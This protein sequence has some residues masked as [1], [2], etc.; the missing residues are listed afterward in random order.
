MSKDDIT[1]VDECLK[2]SQSKIYDNSDLDSVLDTILYLARKYTHSDAGSIYLAESDHLRFSYVQNDTLFPDLAYGNR[3]VYTNFN[4]PI[5]ESSIAGYAASKLETLIID[6]AYALNSSLPYSF[7]TQFDTSSGYKTV[8]MLTLPM[9]LGSS[10]LVGV[11]QL[12]NAT[13][14]NGKRR[15]YAL[16]EVWLAEKL[17]NEAAIAIEKAK[18]TRSI[19]L[20]MI[21]MA[22]LRDPKETG[23]HVN[24]VGAYSIE[25]YKRW[26]K[27]VNLSHSEVKSY[28]DALRISAMLH[29]VGKV[30]ISDLILKKPA[31]LTTDEF[32]IMKLHTVEGA[33]LF[34][35]ADSYMELLSREIALTHH[36]KWD[37]T[38][39]PGKF[40]D[41]GDSV[42]F[43]P[44]LKGEEIPLAGRLVA[45][46]DVYDALVSKR[47]YKDPWDEDKVTE[48]IRSESGKH[49]DPS[50]VDA[51]FEIYDI[52]GAIREKYC[53]S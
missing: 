51:F 39:Y 38:G 5:N 10:K 43:G 7:N 42:R 19:I 20:K 32:E 31:R 21:R 53:D 40:Q 52:I 27:K 33:K 18:M 37:G 17:S 36:E 46:A 30:A 23:A 25:I 12:I 3:H 48:L 29:D 22:G 44:G 6:D 9:K 2:I 26:A 14:D 24:R 50:L 13:T 16:R 49:F 11:L 4:I 1:W 8:S 45:I 34:N 35:E 41:L 15:P 28:T 47:C